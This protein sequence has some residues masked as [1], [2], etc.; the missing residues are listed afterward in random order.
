MIEVIG[1]PWILVLAIVLALAVLALAY[2]SVSRRLA[3]ASR[4]AKKRARRIADSARMFR[5]AE[6]IAGLGVWQYHPLSGRQRWSLGMKQL[7]GIDPDED[8]QAGDLETVLAA[9]GIDLTGYATRTHQASCDTTKRFEIQRLDGASRVLSMRGTPRFNRRG[10]IRSYTAVLMD[11]TDQ[12]RHV[13]DLTA[14]RE[15][16]IEQARNAQKLA[17]TDALTGLANRRRAMADLD[18]LVMQSRQTS[19]PLVLIIFDIDHF[20]QVND[21][22]GHPAGDAVLKRIAEIACQQSRQNDIVGRIGGEEFVWIVP[23]ADL[24]LARV[25][26]ERLRQA[27]ALGSGTGPVPPVTISVGFAAAEAGDTALTLFARADAALYKA[28]DAGRNTIRMAA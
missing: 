13:Q 20:K 3:F 14:S 10:S 7:F 1:V 23:E 17:E 12:V 16:A 19:E 26:S 24:V 9:N 28:K 15:E 6:E 22:H 11:V 21:R 2:R 25:I 5:M 8:V 4:L 18:L 27:I